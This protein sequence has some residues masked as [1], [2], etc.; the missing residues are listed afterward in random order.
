MGALGSL[1]GGIGGLIGA[2]GAG[3]GGR[4]TLNWIASLW[5]KLQTPNFDVRALSPPELKIF[6]EMAPET[7]NAVVPDEVKLATE[8]PEGRTAQLKSL[9][10]LQG[11][12]ENGL[13]VSERI[14]ADNAQRAM[15]QEAGR[16]QAN[17]LSGMAARG[18]AGGGT[19]LA[20]ALGG[21]QRQAELARG[22]GSDLTQQI[23]NARLQAAG[24]VGTL[25]SGMRAADIGASQ[26]N[27]GSTNR[28]NEIVASGRMRAAADAAAARERAQGFNVGQRQNV[29]EANVLNAYKNNVRNQEY[30]NTMAQQGFENQVKKLGGQTSALQNLAALQEGRRAERISAG[31][32]IGAGVG[33]IGD[34]ALGG[35][36]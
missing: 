9:N 28:F 7:Y 33:G 10:Y 17:V 34:V 4:G 31:Q 35:L 27:A 36:I 8:G 18:R 13:P 23:I 14:A 6:A 21:G 32:Q 30:P 20:A 2:A 11:V 22:L 1:G 16:E 25:A 12:Q 5:K 24:Q 15:A 29:G 19:E 3:E 26:Y